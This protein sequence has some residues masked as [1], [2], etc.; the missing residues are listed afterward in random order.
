MYTLDELHENDPTLTVNVVH[1][2]ANEC[3]VSTKLHILHHFLTHDF[4][5]KLLLL[6][7]IKIRLRFRGC[8]YKLTG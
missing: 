7:L 3:L 6:L 8:L 2:S 5:D 4:P 1:I